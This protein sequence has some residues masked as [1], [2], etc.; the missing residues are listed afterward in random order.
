MRSF[1]SKE[2][3]ENFFRYMK[4]YLVRFTLLMTDESLT[5]LAKRVPDFEDYSYTNTILDFKDDLD[6]QLFSYFSL[7]EDDINEITT[8]AD[9]AFDAGIIS[10]PVDGS[11]FINTKYL[12]EAGF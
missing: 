7:T 12:E 8:V 2:E 9:Y 6:S 1:K 4:T 10:A 5:S 3:A 11:E